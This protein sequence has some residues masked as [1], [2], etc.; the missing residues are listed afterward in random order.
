MKRMGAN[1]LATLCIGVWLFVAYIGYKI[2]HRPKKEEQLFDSLKLQSEIHALNEMVNRIEQLDSMIIDL[3]LCRP[4]EV[5]RNF[6]MEWQG[7]AGVNHGFDFLADGQSD[8]SAHLMELAIAE[9]HELNTQV[10][11]RIA[12][13][14]NKAC[15]LSF[16]DEVEKSA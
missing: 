14:Y 1:I 7:T 10:A 11:L 13:I 16:Y 4:S 2:C 6:R 9:R 5:L 3:N 15:A 8:S 12:D